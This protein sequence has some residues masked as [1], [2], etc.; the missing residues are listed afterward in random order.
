MLGWTRAVR[1][2]AQGGGIPAEFILDEDWYQEWL[3]LPRGDPTYWNC[4][5]YFTIRMDAFS[6][7]VL[8]LPEELKRVE[9]RPLSGI[10]NISI[11]GL[12]LGSP[13]RAAHLIRL[14]TDRWG[15][16]PETSKRAQPVEQN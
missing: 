8:E 14:E 1:F 10:H 12:P 15:Q 2:S 13:A 4:L 6:A 5:D 3:D 16:S 9:G 11:D 7:G